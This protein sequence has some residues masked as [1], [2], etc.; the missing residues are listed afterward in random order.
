MTAVPDEATTLQ[1]DDL[2]R[3]AGPRTRDILARR[4]SSGGARRR[5]WL[6]RRVLVAADV[7]GLVLAFVL[8]PALVGAAPP[9]A[10]DWL[11]LVALLPVW[12]L[13]AKLYGLY[14]RDE[15]R[16]AHTTVD[17]VVAVFHLV[18]VGAWLLLLFGT[19]TDLT[20]PALGKLAVFWLLA[21]VLI[22][23]LRALAR[24]IARRSLLYVQ[25]LVIVGAG[26]VGQLVARKVLQHPE[27]GINLIGLID[28][29]QRALRP[30]LRDVPMLGPTRRLAEIVSLFEVDRV[31]VAFTRDPAP[32][33]VSLLRGLGDT[34]VQIDVVPR[35]FEL[36][37]PRIANHSLEALP[38]VGLLPLRPSRSSRWVKR[39]LDVAVS[40]VA[41]V[42]A[43]PL[44]A[45]IA[46]GVRWDSPGPVFFRQTRL[47]LGM[48]QFTTLK[49]RTMPVGGD[50]S[51]HR[52]YIART[53]SA[54]AS[55][56]ANGM[57]KLDGGAGLSRF[58]RFLRRMSLDELPQLFNVLRGDMS[59]VGPRPCIP[60][61]TDYFK[62]HHFER[63]AVPAGMTG[64]WQ[65]HARARSTF[66]DALDMDVTYARGWSLGLDLQLLCRT[67]V[68]V[69]RRRGTS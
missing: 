54:D 10:L 61:E 26:D 40:S 41:L 69:L 53:M 30:E 63:F 8:A 16:A 2:V 39:L 46:I 37:G 56:G 35:L 22:A 21:V 44:F 20:T 31:V 48:R 18:T 29:Q 45:V 67:P 11:T 6:V 49:F 47:G 42:L 23:L 59:L 9:T 60:Y 7:V 24:A 13:L 36:I 28:E 50:D 38:L 5:G 15:E 27:Y 25:N 19:A 55:V 3:V 57:Y 14:D 68:E 58:G 12:V 43:A 33:T 1:P 52:E 65:V 34:D 4:H 66:G 64:Y 62:P 32:Q 51:V 17:D